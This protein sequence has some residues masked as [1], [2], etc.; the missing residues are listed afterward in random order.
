MEVL[1]AI[2][3]R[4]SC[5]SYLREDVEDSKIQTLVVAAN[6]APVAGPF[7]ITVL[8]DKVVINQLED[9]TTQAMRE[10]PLSFLQ[11]LAATPGF[12]PLFDAPGMMVFSAPEQNPYGMANCANAATTAALAATGLYLGS[13][14]VV[15]PTMALITHPEICKKIGIPEG[16]TPLCCLMFGYADDASKGRHP[17]ADATVNYCREA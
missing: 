10:S 1:T 5:R 13:C 15:T 7:H 12:R 8:L 11:K 2:K 6:S 3:N 17:H 4:H 14:F 9:L 16:F